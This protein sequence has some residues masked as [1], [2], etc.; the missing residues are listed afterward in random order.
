MFEQPI[1][2]RY[3]EIQTYF[4][5]SNWLPFILVHITINLRS[6]HTG[7]VIGTEISKVFERQNNKGV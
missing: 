5:L 1:R 2:K 4:T 6:K 7:Q 3:Y